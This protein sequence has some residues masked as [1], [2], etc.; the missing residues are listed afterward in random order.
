MNNNT[1]NL[2]GAA[3]PQKSKW[4]A[5]FLCF[6]FGGF[7]IHRFYVG[8]TG[9]GVIWL[10]TGGMFGVGWLIDFFMILFGAFRDKAGYPLK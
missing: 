2:N 1:N 10:F 4:T 3:Y 6:F 5:F 7:G 9:T 8:K